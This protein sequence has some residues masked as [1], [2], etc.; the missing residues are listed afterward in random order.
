MSNSSISAPR[1]HPPAL[2]KFPPRF[3]QYPCTRLGGGG[4]G[5]RLGRG[6]GEKHYGSYCLANIN[7]YVA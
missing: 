5:T 4:G 7:I 2:F 1:H 3:Y 6:G